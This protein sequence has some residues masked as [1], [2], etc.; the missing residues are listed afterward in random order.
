MYFP[1]YKDL[2]ASS[3]RLLF[4]CFN[5]LRS[6]QCL[7]CETNILQRWTDKS[8]NWMKT[9]AGTLAALNKT[10]KKISKGLETIPRNTI[11][12]IYMKSK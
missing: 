6:D 11:F 1:K 3:I 12:S 8:K 4:L 5:N 7:K 10:L 9:A 2:L